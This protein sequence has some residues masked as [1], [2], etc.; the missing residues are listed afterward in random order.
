M[1]YKQL[2]ATEALLDRITKEQKAIIYRVID[3]LAGS[4]EPHV[5]ASMPEEQ[6]Q[7]QIKG[8]IQANH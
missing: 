8:F 4:I 6:L 3:Q 2:Q 5:N 7:A 1:D